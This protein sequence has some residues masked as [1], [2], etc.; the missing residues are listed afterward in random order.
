MTQPAARSPDVIEEHGCSRR[1]R[2]RRRG[3]RGRVDSA[4]YSNKWTG[5]RAPLPEQ[6]SSRATIPTPDPA[7][8]AEPILLLQASHYIVAGSIGAFRSVHVPYHLVLDTGAGMNVI[9][10]SALPEGWEANRIAAT[11]LPA[12][13]DANGK[14]LR[15]NGAVRLQVRL[16]NTFF[17]T[18]FV[19]VEHLAVEVILGTVFMNR[20][21][22]AIECMKR[23]I[24]LRD[25]GYVPILSADQ[26]SDPARDAA[27]RAEG[28]ENPAVE[29]N[30]PASNFEVSNVV[31]LA[32]G[33]TLPAM[34]QLPAKV[35]TKAAGLV[36]LDPKRSL[37]QRHGI[38]AANGIMECRPDVPF[39]IALANFSKTPKYLPKG[40]IVAYAKRDPATPVCALGQLGREMFTVL[41]LPFLPSGQPTPDKSGPKSG[42]DTNEGQ[43]T[44]REQVDLS[45]VQDEELKEKIYA[46]LAR[47]THMWEP[48]RLGEISVTEHRIE[49]RDGVKPIRQMPYRQGIA[50]RD[51]ASEE[52]R[53]MLEHG[54]IEPA[55][56][57][58]ASPIVFV[59]KKDGT[60]RFCVDYRRLNAVTKPDAYPLP[61]ID[62]CIDSLGEA[63]IFTTLDANAGYWQIA[64]APEDR[65]KTTFT[66]H[67]GTYR[68]T[69]MPFGLRNAPATFQRAL[70]IILSGVRWQT[71]LIYLDDVIVFSKTAQQ[72]VK[73]VDLVLT[74]LRQAGVTLKLKK[75]FWF[76]DRVDYLGH[77]ITPGRLS[78]AKENTGAFRTMLFPRSLTELRSFLGA[79]NVYRRFIKG[80]SKIARP[81]TEMLRKNADPDWGSP[82][83]EAVAAFEEL[84][85]RLVSPPILGLP[86]RGCPYMIDTD[87]SA[88]QLGAALLQQQDPDRP[89][90]WTPIGYWSRTLNSAEQNY[91]AT[92]RECLAV[93]WA[94]GHLRPYVEG[95]RFTIRTDHDALRWL[96]TLTDSSGRLTRWRLRLQEFDFEITYRPGRVHQVPDALSRLLAVKS[97]TEPLDD[98]I[99]S[100]LDHVLV[101]TR[102]RKTGAKKKKP[103]ADRPEESEAMRE[104]LAGMADIDLDDDADEESDIFDLIRANAHD[105]EEAPCPDM[106]TPL[107]IS[108]RELLMAQAEDPYCCSVLDR[109]NKRLGTV[110]FVDRYGVLRREDPHDPARSQIVVPKTLRARVLNMA[111]HS[112]LAGH[113][114]QT[115]MYYTLRQFY[116][117]PSMAADVYNTVR[118]CHHC[119]RNRIRLKKKTNPLA[120]FPATQPL[121]SVC[122]DILGPLPKTKAGMRFL[123][124]IT[125][126]F[127]KLTAVV[128]LRK[129]TS[130]DV[131]KGFVEHW[132][133]KYGPPTDLI[134]D[135]GAQFAGNLFRR[136][137]QLL[138]VT[139]VFTSTYHPQTNGQ[140]ERYNRTV[141]A[142]LR[143]YVG[144]H[145]DDWDLY[146]PMLTYAYNNSVHRATGTTPF[147]LVLSNP[148]PSLI[149]HRSVTE[150]NI[151]KTRRGR[152]EMV[153]RLETAVCNARRRLTKAQERYKRDFDRNVRRA[154]RHIKPGQYVYLDPQDGQKTA[155][156]LGHIA[157]G[158]YRVLLNDGRTFVIQR[159]DVVERVNSDRVTYS[160]P[161]PDAPTP[162][163]FA[164]NTADIIAKNIDGRTYLVDKLLDHGYDADGRLQFLVKWSGYDQP[165]WQP[166]TDI[167]EELISRYF[168]SVRGSAN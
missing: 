80:F 9:R 159:G 107:P 2:K 163:P 97:D 161:P 27:I 51:L 149:V 68:Y 20:N 1:R 75:C 158:P 133:Y 166:R 82:P 12:L 123:L 124:V 152:A 144:E 41:N 16:G 108:Q 56:S 134:S 156:K 127:T 130:A 31:R 55:A 157:V 91:S 8:S 154:N 148:P 143:C 165:S 67:S 119:A 32:R 46:M 109:R 19:V 78:V 160:P 162:L 7:A 132:V 77:V 93:V 135:N 6:N 150:A 13:G 96:M 138:G 168:S 10:R 3:G 22:K 98:D 11:D 44:L 24:R 88:Y 118:N 101:T 64:V 21:V 86:K 65:D 61:R 100:P 117:W 60:K 4:G 125:D 50:M 36:F 106:D 87:A 129:I 126:R 66:C 90:D 146:A 136:V 112:P 116:Y 71:C 48:G 142:M 38:R 43:G 62:E 52:I 167:P 145:Q 113:P 104:E 40:T 137:C 94:V 29:Q 58:W 84:K 28:M 70:D 53:K 85:E 153:E 131:A 115:R 76:Q 81:L 120:L 18:T 110:F 102:S 30:E 141:L 14:P 33:L 49:L 57:E 42:L 83:A 34:A 95:T 39:S 128:P 121:R 105:D 25:D 164:A 26:L 99:P 17:R 79:A 59:P 147:Q 151:G 92:E 114:G 74:L 45:H 155:G 89:T 103:A 23:R 37:A 5:I 72:H 15:V 47:H 63:M 139:N 122:I 73:D 140:V 111:H 35:T 69:R 54:V